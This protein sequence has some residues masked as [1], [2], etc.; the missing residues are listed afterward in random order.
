MDLREATI[1]DLDAITE[2]ALAAF[3]LDSQWHYRFPHRHEFP[4]DT[5]NYTKIGYRAFFDAPKE[6]SY[7]ILATLPS[8]EDPTVT[9]PVAMAV[10]ET[11]LKSEVEIPTRSSQKCQYTYNYF[12]IRHKNLHIVVNVPLAVINPPNIEPR[13]DAHPRRMEAFTDVMEVARRRYFSDIYGADHIHLKILATHPDYRRRGAG[14][15]LCNWG[16]DLAKKN[17][18]Y[19]SVFA[20]PMGEKLYAHLGFKELAVVV[21]QVKGEEEK[22]SITAMLYTERRKGSWCLVT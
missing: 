14:T 7:V 20:S 3:S 18:T 11:N 10:W 6:T 5:E 8:L 16:I 4:K 21:V 2:I 9:K 17:Q 12:L 15:K 22:V 19:I 13:R 1:T